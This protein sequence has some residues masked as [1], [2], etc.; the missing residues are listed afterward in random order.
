MKTNKSQSNQDPYFIGMMAESFEIGHPDFGFENCSLLNGGHNE[1]NKCLSVQ[2]SSLQLWDSVPTK[3][4]DKNKDQYFVGVIFMLFKVFFF[5]SDYVISKY[6]MNKANYMTPLDLCLGIVFVMLPMNIIF[7]KYH[8]VNMNVFSYRPD[9]S[10]V[11]VIRTIIGTTNNICLLYAIKFIS[12]GKIT[13]VKSINPLW[14]AIIAS[15]LIKEKITKITIIWTIIAWFG[16]F[17]LTLNRESGVENKEYS[18]VGYGLVFSSAWL[19]GGVFVCIRYVNINGVNPLM[20]SF[21]VGFGTAIQSIFALA[22]GLL[23]IE[24]Y[25]SIDILW[26]VGI[27]L[28]TFFG[29]VSISFANK[30]SL[31]SKM[32][33]FSNLEVVMCIIVDIFLFNYLFVTTDVIGIWIVAGWVLFPLFLKYR[34]Q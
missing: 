19:F 22:F 28:A 7:C 24:K 34:E 25:D 15:L 29:Q 5:S 11:L 12:I 17:M 32:A 4:T 2:N 18:I 3:I 1:K 21:C 6:A 33:P 20:Q 31:A 10:I 16:I 30:Y 23:N 9:I 27:G 13:L 14:W 8:N 26:L